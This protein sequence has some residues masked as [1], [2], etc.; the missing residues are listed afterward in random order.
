M[1]DIHDADGP[2]ERLREALA[3]DRRGLTLQPGAIVL[4][5]C[6]LVGPDGT[7]TPIPEAT[8]A[9]D[10]QGRCESRAGAPEYIAGVM[11]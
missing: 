4:K 1:H 5:G 6:Y 7:E 8:I 11:L 3:S 2:V 9:W 10:G